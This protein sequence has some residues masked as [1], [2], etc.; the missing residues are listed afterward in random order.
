MTKGKSEMSEAFEEMAEK[1]DEEQAWQA[2]RE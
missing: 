1:V 2:R